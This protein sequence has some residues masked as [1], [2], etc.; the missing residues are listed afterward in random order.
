MIRPTWLIFA[1]ALETIAPYD[2]EADDSRRLSHLKASDICN[3]L[4]ALGDR[5]QVQ[6]LQRFFKTGHGEYGEGG[7]AIEKFPEKLRQ[8]Y[9]RGEI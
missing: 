2:Q 6:I 4:Q 9:L 8:Q 7:Y 5:E 1:P 3:R